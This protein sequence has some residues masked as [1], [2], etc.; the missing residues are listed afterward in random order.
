[1]FVCVCVYVCGGAAE[2][3]C[4]SVTQQCDG[5]VCL[6]VCESVCLCVC[7]FVCMCVCVYVYM[8]GYY[9]VAA[10][11]EHKRVYVSVWV[12]VCV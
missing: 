1:V 12:W 2:A 7:I 10:V 4:Y 6:C 8:C 11:E 3:D 5:M 9:S